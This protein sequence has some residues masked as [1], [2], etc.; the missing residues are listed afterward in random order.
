METPSMIGY[1][2]DQGRALK[3]TFENRAV[4][5]NP[6]CQIFQERDIRKIY[7]LGSGTSYNAATAIK[8]Y[9]EMY[10]PVEAEVM[11]PTVFTNHAKINQNCIYNQDEILVV[12]IS[13]SGTSVSTIEAMKKAKQ[14]GYYTVAITE[15]TESLITEEVDRVVKLTCG[16]EEIP[17][18]TRGYSVTLLQG[19]LT[20]LEVAHSR[21]KLDDTDFELRITRT[22]EFLEHYP[23]I[24][25]QTE[26]WYL[27]NQK[28][29]LNVRQGCVAA[30][31]LNYCT[32]IEAE[33]KLFETF[34]HPVRG[35]EMEEMIHGPQ[36]A[37]DEDTYVFLVAS[38]EKELERVPRFIQFFEENHITEHVFVITAN[39][40]KLKEKDLCF[41]APIPAELSPLVFTLPFQ[42][43]AARN[44]I[45]VGIDTAKRPKNRKA[46][47][48]IYME[49]QS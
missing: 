4:Y 10:L 25:E 13:Q 37:F 46:F 32:A 40:R 28:E 42:I 18:E 19:Y 12:G 7:L 33:L 20:A 39:E 27:A 31:G 49:E 6:F 9:L 30:Y 29:L 2:Q 16:K 36:M 14:E 38:E 22:A 17:V 15:A 26:K 44:C 21:K 23:E 8:Q 48:H 11:I 5:C 41:Y 34:K 1:I 35:Y 45:A 47:A 3:A 43:M 24:M